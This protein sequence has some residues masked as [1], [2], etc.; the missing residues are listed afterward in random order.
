MWGRSMAVG[1]SKCTNKTPMQRQCYNIYSRW[2]ILSFHFLHA[3]GPAL[4]RPGP[5]LDQLWTGLVRA[6]TGSG[7]AW[8]GLVRAWT[9]LD[10]LG[11]A[12]TSPGP[13]PAYNAYEKANGTRRASQAVPHPSTDRALRCLTSEFG[14]DRVHS[15]QYGRWRRISRQIHSLDRQFHPPTP[16]SPP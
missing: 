4:D 14:W 5:G 7:P 11:P 1:G 9:G 12:W 6:W 15:S 2:C 16:P 13:L 8:T 3:S 10:R